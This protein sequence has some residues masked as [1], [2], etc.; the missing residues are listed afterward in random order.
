M[1]YVIV[2]YDAIKEPIVQIMP[3][4]YRTKEKAEQIA[5]KLEQ[6]T[7]NYYEVAQVHIR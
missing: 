1:S 6:E 4:G 5:R 7:G 3:I 2:E